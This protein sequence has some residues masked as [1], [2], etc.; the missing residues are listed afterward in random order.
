MGDR[1]LCL[2]YLIDDDNAQI[3]WHVQKLGAL[4]E[5]IRFKEAHI[6][7]FRS[8]L[9]MYRMLAVTALIVYTA[10]VIGLTRAVLASSAN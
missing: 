5:Q 4:G 2:P 1:E 7:R 6:A 3:D 8:H 10:I 9:L